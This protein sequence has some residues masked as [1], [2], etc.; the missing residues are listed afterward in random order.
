[1]NARHLI[2]PAIITKNFYI[3]WDKSSDLD[4]TGQHHMLQKGL[5]WF[6]KVNLKAP[7]FVK[8]WRLLF[9]CSWWLSCI[10][11]IYI[12]IPHNNLIG[13]TKQALLFPLFVGER[14]MNEWMVKVGFDLK[15]CVWRPGPCQLHH[16][17]ISSWTT[18]SSEAP[19]ATTYPEAAPEDATASSGSPDGQHNRTVSTFFQCWGSTN[20]QSKS[21]PSR[22]A[23]ASSGNTASLF[24]DIHFPNDPSPW[25]RQLAASPSLSKGP[26]MMHWE[27]SLSS[28]PTPQRPPCSGGEQ[29][30][31]GHGG[32]TRETCK[33]RKVFSVLRWT[34]GGIMDFERSHT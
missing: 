22:Y 20:E 11:V 4:I 5:C 10:I 13:L 9:L 28:L 12:F 23:S 32:G 1:M 21:N 16:W 33:N 25:P 17:F 3:T 26:E 29:Q 30:C 2:P 8:R 34:L 6:F 15:F 14:T 7:L 27:M 18:L 31:R 24:F 19:S